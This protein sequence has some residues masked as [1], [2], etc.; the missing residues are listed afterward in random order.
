[1]ENVIQG[2]DTASIAK[3][4]SLFC[5]YDHDDVFDPQVATL[6]AGKLEIAV[7]FKSDA[8]LRNWLH[9]NPQFLQLLL[10]GL[11]DA[12]EADRQN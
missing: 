1:V 10:T 6:I 2:L 8:A 7:G 4:Q 3:L 5:S 12:I 9:A 11:Q